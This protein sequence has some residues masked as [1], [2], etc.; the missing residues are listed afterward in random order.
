MLGK[1]LSKFR[2]LRI[3]LSAAVDKKA[4]FEE[5]IIDSS[6][7]IISINC[8]FDFFKYFGSDDFHK[9]ELLFTTLC[10]VVDELFS[11]QLLDT[12]P[13]K[14]IYAKAVSSGFVFEWHFDKKLFSIGAYY[15]SILYHSDVSV[16]KIYEVL[17]SSER[18]EIA[19][20]CIFMDEISVFQI[21]KVYVVDDSNFCYFFSGPKKLFRS[22]VENILNGPEISTSV[23]TSAFFK[24]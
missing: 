7:T 19:R 4:S 16:Y 14:A 23:N 21:S 10:T 9:R 18:K 3:Y 8:Y 11:F 20:R 15:I 1:N 6:K 22:S 17:Y 2:H 12:E 5:K 24:N 13:I